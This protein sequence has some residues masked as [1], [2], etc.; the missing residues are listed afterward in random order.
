[1][2]EPLPEQR[3]AIQT[4]DRAVIVQAGAGTGKTWVL[5]QRFLYL[6]EQNPGWPIDSL[7][8]VTFTEK[9][10]REMRNRIRQR[11]EEAALHAP[12]VSPWHRR[13]RELDRLQVG[14]IHSLCARILRENAISAGLDPYFSV[15]DEQEAGLLQE[16]AVREALGELVRSG[17]GQGPGCLRLLASIRVRDLHL[18]LES[19]LARRGTLH[20]LFQRL[21]SAPELLAWWDEQ[22]DHS[23]RQAWEQQLSRKPELSSLLTHLAGIPILDD[24]DKL[25]PSVQRAQAGC[26]AAQSGDLAQAFACWQEFDLRGGKK[27]AWGG[28]AALK[29][30]KDGLKSFREAAK[31]VDALGCARRPGP[32]DA[33]AAETL[34]WWQ[35]LWERVE[36][37][38]ARLKAERNAL[39][40]DDLELLTANLLAA[41]T[42]AGAAPSDRL[43][44]F[45]QGINHLMVDEFQ[46][47]N[48]IQQEIVYALAH[49]SDPGRLFVVGDAKQS[50]Y[51]FRQAQVSTF[52]RTAE[53]ISLATGCP[54]VALQHSF[55][56]HQPLVQALNALFEHVLRPQGETHQ[57]YEAPPG[58]LT[59][60]RSA[61]PLQPV[62]PAP[63]EI[64]LLP[65]ESLSGSPLSAEEARLFEARLLAQRLLELHSAGFLVWDRRLEAERPFRFDDAAILFRATTTLPLYEEQFKTAGLPYLTVSGR[66]YYDRPEIQDLLALLSSLYNPADDLNLATALRSPLF[67]LSDETLFRLRWLSPKTEDGPDAHGPVP[68]H[69]AL[70]SPPPNSQP[71]QVAFAA[72]TFS[73]LLAATG[74]VDTWRLL[75]MALDLTGYEA[76][77]ALSDRLRSGGGRQWNNVQKLLDMARQH[78]SESLSAFLRRV[79]D[80]RSREAREGEALAAAPE[81]GAVQLMSIHAAKGLEFP[82]VA[83]A[84]LGR[85][86]RRSGEPSRLLA[87]PLFGLV[88]MFRDENGDWQKPESYRWAEGLNGQMEDA[89]NKRLLYVACTRAADLLILSGRSAGR[90]RS[91]IDEIQSAWEIPTNDQPEELI[92]R[93]GY[94]LRLLRPAYQPATSQASP[95]GS[96]PQPISEAPLVEI[97]PLARPVPPDRRPPALAVTDLVRRLETQE[98]ESL[99]ALRPIA[100]SKPGEPSAHRPS[101]AALGRMVHR[102]LAN[103]ACLSQADDQLGCQLEI[104]AHQEGI[105]HPDAVRYA[106][107][108]TQRM[109]SGLRRSP[110]FAAIQAA[111]QRHFELPFTLESSLG[112][113]QGVIDLLFQDSHGEWRLIEWKTEWVQA[114]QIEHHAQEHLLQMA[115][116][117]QAARHILGIEPR[118]S[119]CFLAAGAACVD[120]SPARLASGWQE[121]MGETRLTALRKP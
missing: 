70:G 51:R 79:Q 34:Q 12:P 56:T 28:E 67:N 91:W 38:Y 6:L 63:V 3:T 83:V 64:Y 29:E 52:N 102:T 60:E 100:G 32:L 10:A 47:T 37:R 58:P 31:A 59:A 86:L 19:M 22:M 43:R 62:A 1:M 78:S 66:G 16:Q 42:A 96:E 76:T 85:T 71:E 103:W 5:V 119:V 41:E 82:V 18:Q 109:L 44:L 24:G 9:A 50:I 98:E 115:A 90:G 73:A 68:Y 117:A 61:P 95:Q 120:Y 27:D 118:V 92:D 116:Y 39:D 57:P 17:E 48:P 65:Q 30:L 55:R 74:R 33:H 75:R 26:R 99:P 20:R 104:Y 108:R 84:D 112:T 13:R 4:T 94:S 54:P 36:G 113:L 87:D 45:L 25:A 93:G 89:E 111:S 53:D 11:V 77:L 7:V 101:A 106:V 81:S 8:A 69:L 2:I 72:E 107:L 105:L 110:L 97:P 88:P 46:D 49:P 35:E 23:R 80:L 21:P 114:G 40:F 15:L 14:T 121:L